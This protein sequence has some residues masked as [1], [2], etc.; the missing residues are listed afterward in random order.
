M[1]KRVQTYVRACTRVRACTL[2][3]VV[4]YGMALQGMVCVWVGGQSGGGVVRGAGSKRAGWRLRV[5][6]RGVREEGVGRAWLV[7]RV[8]E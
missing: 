1:H 6:T 5:C 8:W 2:C 7:Q 4:L 3:G